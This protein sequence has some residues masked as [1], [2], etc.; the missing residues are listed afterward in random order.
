MAPAAR[1]PPR[2]ASAARRALRRGA[3]AVFGPEVLTMQGF[4]HA[5]LQGVN[6]GERGRE[7]VGSAGRA[8]AGIGIGV[9][10]RGAIAPRGGAAIAAAGATAALP[11]IDLRENRGASVAHAHPTS[12]PPPGLIVTSA[13]MIWKFLVVLTGS[14]SPVRER[15]GGKRG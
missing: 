8:A 9:R 13:L 2:R 15:G 1:P 12:P 11:G 14:E 5:L 10:A 7:M 6:L 4:K 3:E